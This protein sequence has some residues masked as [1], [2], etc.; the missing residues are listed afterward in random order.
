M[1]GP[2]QGTRPA[3][4]GPRARE[5]E[6]LAVRR[7]EI[8]GHLAA[9]VTPA[10]VDEH[11]RSPAGRHSPDL[12]QVLAYLRQVPTRGKLAL[13][14]PAAGPLRILRLSGTPGVPHDDLGPAVTA[15][16][17]GRAGAPG[18]AAA[19]DA[20]AEDAAAH[21]VFERRIRALGA[22]PRVDGGSE[23]VASRP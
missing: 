4:R 20:P 3:A 23:P 16:T 10:L 15:E 13:R 5:E 8:E 9:L 1:K 19:E 17:R 6:A 22:H 2:G 7:R 18:E 14:K 21:E 12:G 11:R